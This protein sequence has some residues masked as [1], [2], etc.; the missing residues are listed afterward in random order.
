VVDKAKAVVDMV[1]AVVD[2]AK[3]D[4]AKEDMVK[5][6][7]VKEDMAKVDMAK[8]DM[9]KEDMVKVDMVKEDMVKEDMAKEDM[10]K[11]DM[12]KE[13]MAKEDTAK[14]DMVKDD[15]DHMVDDTVKDFH[16]SNYSVAVYLGNAYYINYLA[17]LMLYRK[18][19]IYFEYPYNKIHDICLHSYNSSYNFVYGFETFYKTCNCYLHLREKLGHLFH[20]CYLFVCKMPLLMLEMTYNQ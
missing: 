9:V 18:G 19:I 10:A 2:M 5:E 14:E 1:K 17:E 3:V 15:M 12:V 16:N 13:D 11:E 6:D 8:V 20:F 4:M 7:M